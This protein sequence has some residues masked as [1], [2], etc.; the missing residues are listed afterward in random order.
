MDDFAFYTFVDREY[1][2]PLGRF[3][4]GPRY[5]ELVRSLLPGGWTLSRA[6]VWL[7]AAPG[8]VAL[9]PQGFKIHLSCAV[10]SADAMLR[11][12]VPVC[13]RAGVA[14]KTVADPT[15]H[16][17]INSKRYGRGG[18][19]K[20]ATIY[21]PDDT[22]F[23][24]LLEELHGATQGLDGPYIL[25]D[26]RYRDSRVVYYRYGGFQRID[27]LNVDGTR[28]PMIQ[29]PDGALVAD[30]RPPYFRL[31]DWVS[32]PAPGG[33]RNAEDDGDLLNGRYRVEEALT[34]SNTGGIYRAV[35]VTTGARVVI[36]EA[37]PHTL[38]WVGR[39]AIVESV[40][41]LRHE[42]AVL[43]RL[44]GLACVPQLVELYTEWEH[45]FLVVSYFD[46]LPL[47]ELRARDDVI[48]MT[49]LHDPVH[50]ARFCAMWRGLCLRLLD[51]VT[52]IHARGVIVG[53]ISPGNVLADLERGEIAIID[54]EGAWLAGADAEM[55]RFGTQWFNPG[56][57]KPE[58]RQSSSLTFA[59]DFYACGMLLYN[60]VCPVQ[61]MFELDSA[62]PT[63]RI[64][65]Y[66]VEQGLPREVRHIIQSLLD[67]RPEDARRSAEEWS[68]S[69]APAPAALV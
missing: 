58:S 33:D 36:K 40:A 65:D 10:A 52:A 64:L 39:N 59:D 53:D 62:H 57:R 18:S 42:H 2:E 6:D 63:F 11:R 8:G 38:T 21:P 49:R 32:D 28:R 47:A 45:A 46:G 9:R 54:L 26:R 51:A 20:F 35:D 19:G 22:C 14:F 50:V 48:L 13:V 43:E 34:F 3:A 27:S 23:L 4:I 31:P 5:Q 25:S 12:I 16:S 29:R 30:E 60:L 66:F 68:P 55:A 37:R 67:G 69:E 61:V 56:F 24:A 41:A 7:S 15:L 17:F 44:R 1:F